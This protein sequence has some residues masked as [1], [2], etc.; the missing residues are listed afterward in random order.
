MM[1]NLVKGCAVQCSL[2]T[3]IYILWHF[4]PRV[5]VIVC[6]HF[7]CGGNVCMLFGTEALYGQQ[8]TVNSRVILLSTP[9]ICTRRAMAAH[10]LLVLFFIYVCITTFFICWSTS[11]ITL[12]FSSR[13]RLFSVILNVFSLQ[14]CLLSL[15]SCGISAAIHKTSGIPTRVVEASPS[16]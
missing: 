15:T 1:L 2:N 6:S 3:H 10:V 13:S 16:E 9:A 7:S 5:N 4:I 12:Q 14:L 11:S 8:A